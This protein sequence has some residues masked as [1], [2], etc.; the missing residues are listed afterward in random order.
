METDSHESES[1]R[2][3]CIV[4]S[5]NQI[6]NLLNWSHLQ[7]FI[8]NTPMTSHFH[9]VATNSFIYA[10]DCALPPNRRRSNRWRIPSPAD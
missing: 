4:V 10:D 3:E 9:P 2:C 6:V 5:L 7:I 8:D 1:A